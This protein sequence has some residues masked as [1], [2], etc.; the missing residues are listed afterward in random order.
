MKYPLYV[1]PFVYLSGIFLRNYFQNLSGFWHD[2]R[3]SLSEKPCF[4][5]FRA[6]RAKNRPKMKFFK[7]YEKSTYGVFLFF[8]NLSNFLKID[9]NGLFWGKILF[10]SLLENKF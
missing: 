9:L 6:K 7:F 10:S 2:A 8:I 4:G 1:R 5:V 3:V